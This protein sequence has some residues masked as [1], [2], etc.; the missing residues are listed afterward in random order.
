[1]RNKK[2]LTLED[3]AQFCKHNQLLSF[4]AADTGYQLVVQVPMK[5]NFEHLE[6]QDT[7]DMMFCKVKVCHTL[8]NRNQSY[9]TEDVM[10]EA[11]PSLKYRPLLAYI[12]QLD[13]GSWDFHAHDMEIDQDGD[14][15][16]TE[17]QVGTFTIDDPL[18]EYDAEHDKTYVI[19]TVAIPEVYTKAADII[20]TKGGT[21]V[22]CEIAIEDMAFNAKENYLEI[23]KFYFMGCTCLGSE[24]DGTPVLPGME[25]AHL[26]ITDFNA[27]NN[28]ICANN[29]MVEG[30]SEMNHLEELL[31]QYDVESVEFETEGLT[32]EELDALF[33]E[34]FKDQEVEDPQQTNEEPEEDTEEDV[35]TEPDDEEEVEPEDEEDIVEDKNE[36]KFELSHDDIRYGLWGLLDAAGICAYIIEVYD[37]CFIYQNWEDGCCY[38]VGYTK[39]GDTVV[40]GEDAVVVTAEWLT[41][42][43]KAALNGLKEHYNELKQFKDDYDA[44]QLRVQREAVLAQEEYSVLADD[45]AFVELVKEQANYSIDELSAMAKLIFADY[46]MKNGVFAL[47]A[48]PKAQ[49]AINMKLNF[50]DAE[51]EKNAYGDLFE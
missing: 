29:S 41:A 36:I 16:Y 42:D 5:A 19:A 38:R 23:K 22:S 7:Q 8:L 39:D 6:E 33:A 26:S 17:S 9:I 1:M 12:H 32:D 49:Q 40:M 48:E 4:S 44:E 10:T 45:D 25:G 3:L 50:N 24:P 15:V 31:K 47:N 30:V 35:V 28:S 21:D 27:A 37:N 46:I 20:R 14:V 51:N 13:D 11:L 18:L 43:E 34:H 2:L